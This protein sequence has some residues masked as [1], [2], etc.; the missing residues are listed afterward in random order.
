MSGSRETKS[1]AP[2]AGS[3]RA[4]RVADG[5]LMLYVLSVCF[6][7]A[8]AQASSILAIL[9]WLVGIARER[10][11]RGRF[12]L[13]RPH[14]VFAAASVLAALTAADVWAGF[15]ELRTEWAPYLL[16]VTVADR[17]S[18]ASRG[19]R[20]LDILIGAGTVMALWGLVQIAQR[21]VEFRVTGS[22]GYMTYAEIMMLIVMVVL[23]RMIFEPTWKSAFR[24]L[25]VLAVM[26]AALLLT[27]TRGAW[28]GA[29]A[30]VV[31]LI[32]IRDRRFLVLVP[33]AA[34]LVVLVM[35]QP[36]RQR[37]EGV[38]D[39]T[40]ITANERVFMWRAGVAMVRDHPL[41]GV[42]PGNVRQAWPEYR[43]PDDPW[44]EE[45]G[46]THMHS[47]LVQV[48]AER[49]LLGL[50][51]WIA[52]WV[53]WFVLAFRSRPRDDI[54]SRARWATGIAVTVAFLV[55]GLTEWAYGD[56]EIVYLA[57]FLMA[58]PLVKV[59]E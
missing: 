51:T 43:L 30:G 24:W 27:Q 42:G 15:F 21:G 55:A 35:P 26:V 58:L 17:M 12:P 10:S 41:T 49:G 28:L 44:L 57:Y 9:A 36:V 16:M 54:P 56:T 1:R 13:L 19:R 14:L 8:M 6:S 4:F 32:W 29:M 11:A 53:A 40:D 38:L 7:S 18:V 59:K 50:V 5:A 22:M 23:G 25:P 20:L 34:V 33:V 31:V 39:L 37:L 47:N 48:A 52:I 2:S 3:G 46:W 45:R